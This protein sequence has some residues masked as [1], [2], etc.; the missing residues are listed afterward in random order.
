M[1]VLDPTATAAAAAEDPDAALKKRR[2]R[3]SIAADAGLSNPV[4][5]KPTVKND[6]EESSRSSATGRPFA[7]TQ[8]LTYE[9]I[10]NIYADVEVAASTEELCEQVLNGPEMKNFEDTLD[11]IL[12]PRVRKHIDLTQMEEKVN[13]VALAV[14]PSE[15]VSKHNLHVIDTAVLSVFVLECAIKI[16]ACGEAPYRYF[17][18]SWNVFDFLIV[19]V[20]VLGM[21]PHAEDRMPGAVPNSTAAAS[22]TPFNEV[23]CENSRAFGWVA[24]LYFVSLIFFGAWMLPTVIIGITTIA[25]AESTEEIKEEYAQLKLGDEASRKAARMFETP[26]MDKSFLPQIHDLYRRLAECQAKGKQIEFHLDSTRQQECNTGLRDLTLRPLLK[27]VS[28]KY[29]HGLCPPNR[30]MKDRE[31]NAIIAYEH[32]PA[33]DDEE[34]DEDLDLGKRKGQKKKP[35]KHR[36]KKLAP[37]VQ[38]SLIGRIKDKYVGA[39]KTHSDARAGD[40][41][42]G[43]LGDAAAE[44]LVGAIDG[45]G[46]IAMGSVSGLAGLDAEPVDNTKAV[47]AALAGADDNYSCAG[48]FQQYLDGAKKPDTPEE[49]FFCSADRNG[50]LDG[51][52]FDLVVDR[53]PAEAKTAQ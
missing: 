47:R 48:G 29:K 38:R 49:A 46:D 31:A 10:R 20:S 11:L 3:A 9:N 25:F 39:S 15:P 23:P 24:A 45:L 22:A 28:T 35:G 18:D 6:G 14:T 12:I 51:G 32:A 30:P 43:D 17:A 1:S 4:N 19:C 13:D 2:K 33:P 53:S 26:A 34:S 36:K 44:G 42:V 27:F 21:V 37:K 41:V 40:D 50:F 8:V 16:T 5:M 7:M 52:I